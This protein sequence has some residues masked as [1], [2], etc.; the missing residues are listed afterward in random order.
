M[1]YGRWYPRQTLGRLWTPR[2]GGTGRLGRHYRFIDRTAHRLAAR[3]FGAM[4]RHGPRLERRQVLLGHLME[5]G[6]ELFVMAA[7][8]AYARSGADAGAE[9]DAE[10]LADVFCRQARRRIDEHFRATGGRDR[11]HINDLAAAVL[12]GKFLW[13]E[14]GIIPAPRTP[15]SAGHARRGRLK[16]RQ[17]ARS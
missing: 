17:R 11:R 14:E 10:A 2:H 4:A 7:T 1:G 13:V 12:D 3:L 15:S 5:I 9:G 6:T 16:T 8:C